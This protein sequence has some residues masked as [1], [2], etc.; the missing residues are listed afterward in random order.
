MKNPVN[1]FLYFPECK[2]IK[3][4]YVPHASGRFHSIS[5][6][7]KSLNTTPKHYPQHPLLSGKA[8]FYFGLEIDDKWVNE[9]RNDYYKL[10]NQ[11]I[12]DPV[13]KLIKQK[14]SLVTNFSPDSKDT[15]LDTIGIGLPNGEIL[16]YNFILTKQEIT[17][18]Y[19]VSQMNYLVHSKGT[20]IINKKKKI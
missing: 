4:N 14:I 19:N 18:I 1:N 11:F 8:D 16:L 15:K 10:F 9:F 3:A 17:T 13:N 2:I 5:L 7:I 20:N 6:Y 12:S